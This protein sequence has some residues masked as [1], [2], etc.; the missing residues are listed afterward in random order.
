MEYSAP[1]AFTPLPTGDPLYAKVPATAN[2]HII[3]SLVAVTGRVTHAS[4]DEK[5]DRIETIPKHINPEPSGTI[6]AVGQ[7]E[8]GNQRR[9]SRLASQQAH[10]IPLCC[11]SRHPTLGPPRLPARIAFEMLN[12][13][14]W[15][16]QH[17]LA[18]ALLDGRQLSIADAMS[19]DRST[20]EVWTGVSGRRRRTGRIVIRWKG[21]GRKDNDGD[22]MA[23]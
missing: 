7:Y 16:Y 13:R 12:R 23:A 18:Y 21:K 2:A 17:A 11:L 4:E 20:F 19:F 10:N 1:L 5:Q 14:I 6:Q 22:G 3:P 9:Y 15:S 8:W